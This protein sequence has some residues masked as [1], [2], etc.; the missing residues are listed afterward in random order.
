M[1]TLNIH[2]FRL[3]LVWSVFLAYCGLQT[4]CTPENNF[5]NN[6]ELQ[7]KIQLPN[8]NDLKST[9][10]TTS[11]KRVILTVSSAARGPEE[12]ELNVS[13]NTATGT[14]KIEQGNNINFTAKAIDENSIVQWQ[15]STTVDIADNF[16][17]DITLSPILPSTASLEAIKGEESVTLSWSQNSDPD[18]GRYELYKSESENSIGEIVHSTSVFTET[19]YTDSLVFEGHDYFY[20]LLVADTEGLTATSNTKE[21]SFPFVPPTESIVQA[22]SVRNTVLVSWTQNPDKDFARYVLY[23]SETDNIQGDSIFSTTNIAETEYLDS[24]VEEGNIYYY[25]LDVF[26]LVGL[27]T[28]SDQIQFEVPV[29]SPTAS[30]LEGY[31]E[32]YDE[33]EYVNLDWSRNS[34]SD[35]DRYELYRSETENELGEKIH[36]STFV[37]DTYFSDYPV[38]EGKIYYYTLVVYNS[39][40]YSSKSNVVKIDVPGIP[41][42]PSKLYGS[43]DGDAYIWWDEN[44]DS[45]FAK[46]ELYRSEDENALGTVIHS[47]DN[48][49]GI[50]FIDETVVDGK[51]Y[52]YTLLVYDV[53]GFYSESNVVTIPDY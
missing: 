21:I 7:L 31:Y 2:Q 38:T 6:V 34:D 14:I 46:Y 32:G 40:E 50:Y 11:I 10:S 37:Y 16:T 28:G 19:E 33:Y 5:D 18:F 26:D 17:V 12:F 1:K 42:Y 53:N 36:S 22:D 24:L 4:A 20:S 48:V 43:L 51:T 49:A 23:R 47:S 25:S 29:V 35:F 13:G 52:Y 3:W 27:N 15:G 9:S 8:H 30:T 44:Y 45:D 41:P 39:K